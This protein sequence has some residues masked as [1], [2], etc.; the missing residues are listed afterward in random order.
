MNITLQIEMDRSIEEL[1]SPTSPPA[2]RIQ[3]TQ[4]DEHPSNQSETQPKPVPMDTT[5][6]SQQSD[7]GDQSDS[8]ET[9][10]S[11]SKTESEGSQS[12][13]KCVK[14]PPPLVRNMSTQVLDFSDPLQNYQKSKDESIFERKGSLHEITHNVSKRYEHLSPRYLLFWNSFCNR[15]LAVGWQCFK[16]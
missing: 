3:D 12:E 11:Q 6:S 13:Q 15:S 16:E 10:D 9:A 2:G 1:E 14:H 5:E 8:K 4:P 7:S